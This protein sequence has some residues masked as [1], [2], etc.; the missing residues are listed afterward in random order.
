V[1]DTKDETRKKDN[2]TVMLVLLGHA[3]VGKTAM[4]TQYCNHFFPEK[5]EPTISDRYK[6]TVSLNKKRVDV[7]ILDT[8]GQEAYS[9]LPEEYLKEGDGFMIIY[10]VDTE[11]SFERAQG[12][13]EE[14]VD[15]RDEGDKC[16]VVL[17][18]NRTDLGARRV[19]SEARGRERLAE[20]QEAHPVDATSRVVPVD[21][22]EC[23]AK[24]NDHIPICFDILTEAL[25]FRAASMGQEEEED[26][27]ATVPQVSWCAECA[28]M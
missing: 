21:Y 8:A 5:Y 28:L 15:L 13:F 23:S 6:K 10:G 19:V 26:W 27:T 11:E 24:G 14:L 22:L 25:L 2:L 20:W 9:T 1:T 18:G 12:I 3:G 17:V 16:P 7:H 4:A